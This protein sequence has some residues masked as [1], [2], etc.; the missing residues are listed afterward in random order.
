MLVP[1]PKL[2]PRGAKPDQLVLGVDVAPR[3]LELA[4]V[5]WPEP[6]TGPSFASLLGTAQPAWRQSILLQRFPEEI[7][8]QVPD[9]QAVHIAR[10][11]H[12][13]Y[14][15]LE[16]MDEL[17]DLRTDPVELNNRIKSPDAAPVLTEL[18][19]ELRR[20][21]GGPSAGR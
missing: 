14:P 3:I 19:G 17:H 15:S 7:V 2:V 1:W 4:G 16:G 13:R 12:I 21:V 9:W 10:W 8:P 18:Q 5:T 11:K 6:I 20:L